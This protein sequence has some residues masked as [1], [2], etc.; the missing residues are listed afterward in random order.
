MVHNMFCK[1]V[2]IYRFMFSWVGLFLLGIFN[3]FPSIVYA[4]QASYYA[5]STIKNPAVSQK[6]ES[7]GGYANGCLIGGYEIPKNGNG[8]QLMRLS[9]NRFY[10]HPDL[11]DFIT[12]FSKTINQNK[13]FNGILIGDTGSPI[14]GPMPSGHAS[15]QN[16]LDVDIWLMEA[17]GAVLSDNIRETMSS[18]SHVT[19]A[20]TMRNSWTNNHTQFVLTAANHK[21]VSRI[22]V[23]PAIKKRIC[24]DTVDWQKNIHA[25]AKIRP[26]Y[27]HDSH[28]HVRLRCP[29]DSSLCENQAPPVQ[30]HGCTGNDI[31]WWFSDGARNPPVKTQIPY[32]KSLQDLPI[33]C[34]ELFHQQK[35]LNK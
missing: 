17:V 22:F 29:S 26:W 28:M 16:G 2:K 13:I 35:M 25:L 20:Q 1:M 9:R 33:Q 4:H 3:F 24:D 6:S 18:I 34:Q 32:Q 5:L 21:N 11:Y 31:D 7:V 27:G 14:G 30:H 12:D 8:F 15:H 10:G 23:N 19:P